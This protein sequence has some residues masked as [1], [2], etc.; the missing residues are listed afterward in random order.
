MKSKKERY[1]MN[2]EKLK[3]TLAGLGIAGLI[4]GSALTFTGCSKPEGNS[5]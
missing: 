5:S 4:A 1:I 2:L 3:K